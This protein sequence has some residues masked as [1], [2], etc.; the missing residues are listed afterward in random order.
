M[1]GQALPV[2]SPQQV[3]SCA[4]ASCCLGC[5]GGNV[6]PALD[7]VIS[8][9][10][11]E[12]E[13]EYPYDP[14]WINVCHF[15]K[16]KV[17]ATIKSWKYATKTMNETAMQVAS[18]ARGPLSI[19]VDAAS[20]QYYVS[21]VIKHPCSRSMDHCVQ[22]VGWGVATPSTSSSTGSSD[23][24]STSHS[25]G[26]S[27]ET[28]SPPTSTTKEEAA[29]TKPIPYWLVRNSWGTSWG[30]QGYLWVERGNNECGIAQ[31]AVF[32]EA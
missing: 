19:C 14:G 15:D 3:V 22:I 2:L 27:T 7:Y 9:G 6:P 32:V 31:E 26:P 12:S 20:W 23:S 28:P 24:T 10:G 8:A 17:M 29:P 4:P 25:G 1:G 13:Q 16:S 11:M 5:E 18:F 30:L 21:G